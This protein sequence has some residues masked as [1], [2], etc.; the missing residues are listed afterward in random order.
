MN[1][2]ISVQLSIWELITLLLAF[3]GACAAAGGLLLKQTQKHL[4][5][6]FATQETGRAEYHR[7][8]SERLEHI[9]QAGRAEALE[10]ARVEREVLKLFAELPHN[11]VMR[12]DYIR[13]QSVI[14]AKLDGLAGS[15]ERRR[16]QE[17]LQAKEKEA[18]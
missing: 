2:P 11:Y 16:L 13:G 4:D 1:A 3:F 12:Q 5:E 9:E 8:I 15:L 14:E 17:L 18:A 10:I 6:R 7:Q